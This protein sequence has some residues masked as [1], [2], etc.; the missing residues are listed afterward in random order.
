MSAKT[1][2]LHDASELTFAAA[3]DI[4]GI[5]SF[6]APSKSQRGK[7]NTVS[8]DTATGDIHCDCTAALV[9]TSSCWHAE[10]IGAAWA[11]H[12]ARRATRHMTIAKLRQAGAKARHLCDFY[13]ARIWR[14]VPA[15]AAMLVACR[16]EWRERAALAESRNGDTVAA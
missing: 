9:G 12:D 1:L 15:D 10:W 16:C 8:L 7:V 3:D 14:C 4:T 11:G 13:R 5:V 2:V 6:T